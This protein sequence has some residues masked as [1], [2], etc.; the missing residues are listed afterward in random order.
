MVELYCG[1][2]TDLVAFLKA[3]VKLQK[4]KCGSSIENLRISFNFVK[5]LSGCIFVI[6]HSIQTFKGSK[7]S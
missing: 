5:G 1:S 6:V 4:V 7:E 3:T 2:T